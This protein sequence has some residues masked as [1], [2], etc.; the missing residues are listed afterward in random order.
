MVG[1]AFWAI[2]TVVLMGAS[3]WAGRPAVKSLPSSALGVRAVQ[4]VVRRSDVGISVPQ[5]LNTGD[6]SAGKLGSEVLRSA[7][8]GSTIT[9][10]VVAQSSTEIWIRSQLSPREYSNYVL[11]S[12]T[13]T[14]RGGWRYLGSTPL[15]HR[16]VEL[17]VRNGTVVGVLE[18][19]DAYGRVVKARNG[20]VAIQRVES[21]G[22]VNP[23]C[24][25]RLGKPILAR[26]TPDTVWN[27]PMGGL[28]AHSLV[29]YT[30]YGVPGYPLL[31]GGVEDYGRAPCHTPG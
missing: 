21:A 8:D 12:A 28:P 19:R 3:V 1:R 29:Q 10:E 2:G 17:A 18:F 7:A 14:W 16:H 6:S 20:W 15:S 24:S 13:V 27:S 4:Q 23:G 30:V 25:A 9:G 26:I 22:N 5:R 31:L 11:T